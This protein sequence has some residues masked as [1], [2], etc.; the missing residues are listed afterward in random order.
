VAVALVAVVA[1][2]LIANWAVLGWNT[3]MSSSPAAAV[4]S[5]EES[6][7]NWRNKWVQTLMQLQADLESKGKQQSS[8]KLCKQLI[9]EILGGGPVA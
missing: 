2:P 5:E 9:W 3:F 7:A 8:L 4:A 1:Y 6:A